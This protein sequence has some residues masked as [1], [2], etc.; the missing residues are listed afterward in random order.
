MCKLAIRED[1]ETKQEAEDY[2]N[3]ADGEDLG[4]VTYKEV[5]V[6]EAHHFIGYFFDSDSGEPPNDVMY[7]EVF[8]S[9][10][11][12]E[13]YWRTNGICCANGHFEYQR[14]DEIKDGV[15][16]STELRFD[17]ETGEML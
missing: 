11:H 7:Q 4:Y 17:A 13:I 16:V 6:D 3:S 10:Q 12:L 5:L 2:V 1:I 9:K 8:N 15:V 14:I